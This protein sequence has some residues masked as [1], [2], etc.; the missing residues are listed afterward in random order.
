MHYCPQ[1]TS[2]DS[3]HSC[4]CLTK[5]NHDLEEQLRQRDAGPNTHREK[6]EAPVL[7]G[8]TEKDQK[9]AMP[10]VDKSE[11][12]TSCPSVADTALLHMVAK[13]QMMKERMDFMMNALKGRVSNN[14]DELV[15]WTD[16]PFIAPI[17]SFPFSAKFC[18]P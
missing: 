10:Q 9:V 11:K 8:G 17:T 5:Q 3:S 16:S 18:M 6:Q 2:T 7:K 1:K 12:I 4:E 14:L 13:M 15:H